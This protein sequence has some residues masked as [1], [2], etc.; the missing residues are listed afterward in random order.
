MFKLSDGHLHGLYKKSHGVSW[1]GSLSYIQAGV[2][3]IPMTIG[4]ERLMLEFV[5]PKH[6]TDV[7][8][9]PKY[10]I[11][12]LN[13]HYLLRRNFRELKIYRVNEYGVMEI[14]TDD[15]SIL[16]EP[17]L[18]PIFITLIQHAVCHFV[19]LTPGTSQFIY[20]SRGRY[21]L[22][23]AKSL[24]R[25]PSELQLKFTVSPIEELKPPFFG[26]ELETIK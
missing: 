3:H 17:E 4:N 19:S 11:T 24:T 9:D 5:I 22:M 12:G 23:M 7:S 8:F 16:S 2:E 15:D 18:A 20:E 26:F 25:I 10:I 13:E 1:Y 21:S 6:L 14:V